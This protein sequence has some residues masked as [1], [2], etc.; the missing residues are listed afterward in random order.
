MPDLPTGTVTFLFTDVEGSTR[1][2]LQMGDH[3]ADL[4]VEYRRLLRAAFQDR[5]GQEIDT[6]GD[7]FF[8]AFPRAKDAVL[9]AV[10]AQR[11]IAAQY[12]PQD[13]A[14]RVRM[15][16]HTGE[17]LSA[18]TGYVGIDVNRAARICSAGHGGQ[19]L[20][21]Q[22]TRN[23]VEHDLPEGVSLRDLSEHRLKDLARPEHVYQ[24]VMP[25]L[26]SE[27]LPLKSLNILPNN[28]PIQ[29]AS[30]IGRERE[31]AE[32]KRLL[33][34][35]RLLTLIGPGGCGKTRLALHVVA[36]LI[37]EFPDGVWLAELAAVSDPKRVP[38]TVASA[39]G[40][41]EEPGRALLTTLSESLRAK[42]LLLVL[43]NCEHLVP[44]CADMANALLLVNPKL[45]I[46]TTSRQTLGTGGETVYSVPSLCVPDLRA[47]PSLEDLTQSEAV[48]LFV[49]RATL[50]RP[51]F[52][53][54]NANALAVAQICRS[55]DGIPLAIEL[56]AARVKVLSMPQIADRLEKRFWLLTGG[57]RTVLPR[58]QTLQAMMDWSY[59][60]LVEKERM[61]L[62]RLAVFVSGFALET[63][64]G[65]CVG[66]G[67]TEHEVMDLLTH[68]VDR[69]LVM[70][71][72]RGAETR[73]RL[74]E[75]V[76][77]YSRD[78]LLESGE[79][80]TVRK[81]HRDWYLALAER[82][83]PMLLGPDE[84]CLDRLEIE[85]DNLRAAL[86]QSLRS[87]EV[88]AGLRLA[89]A[90]S[91]FWQVRG[92]W[93]E[94]R[95]WL[96]TGL[97]ASSGT[98]PAL[99][100]KAMNAAGIL[101]LN[102]GDYERARALSEASLV[103]QRELEDKRGI[104]S[105]LRI[106]GNVMYEQGNYRAA[107]ELHE[108]S[109]AYG[110]EVDDKHAVA[111]SLVNLAIVAD[112]EGDYGRAV[113]LCEESLTLFREV[114]DT[115]G[116]AFALNMLGIL[117]SDQGDY[118]TARSRYEESL[119]IQRELGDKRGIASSLSNLARVAREQSDY[120]AARAL[121]E[122]S[123]AL[124]RE[125][126][127][128][129]GIASS[130]ANLGL[131]AWRQGDYSRATTL[132]GESLIMRRAQGNKAGIAECLEGFAR[133]AQDP[134]RA[135]R[136]FAA[137]AAV[138]AVVGA[139]LPPSDRPDYDRQLN[140]IRNGLGQE[141]F[142]AAWEQGWAMTLEQAIQNALAVATIPFNDP[143]TT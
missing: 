70:V 32:V 143:S 125:L 14:L 4:L 61:L 118:V 76:R 87:G 134:E 74:L 51:D 19:I 44:E 39:L 31:M 78:R 138:R 27:F 140:A 5:G 100:A 114:R 95:Q 77:Q 6:P 117:A 43:D 54:T 141:G 133:V 71:D 57:S 55:L 11:A 115:R 12:W 34:A 102:Q 18:A 86:E 35:T 24:V 83:E 105:S 120:T 85:H 136:L 15:A 40:V 68:L 58:Q 99:R 81:R 129:Q 49:E 46:L 67:V 75:T 21:S 63:A 106:L 123:L 119:V 45:K 137:A 89:G 1:L 139:P 122:E 9:A 132:F 30:F 94:G 16:L 130:L 23:L 52:R 25:D 97:D 29:L 113:S 110:R 62:R 47:R 17:P 22:T 116:T 126:G 10:A 65:V 107:G 88:E 37:D 142:A 36:D 121:Y 109:L 28:L 108:Q 33:S 64:E 104:G 53:L 73:Y 124:R 131:V 7:A 60:L 112:H 93:T 91:R 128:K 2:L 48:R 96:E 79:T 41:R 56:A 26:P 101:A 90:L 50:S 135:A 8:A 82:T 98:A 3:Y 80:P 13:I 72:Q 103:I 84:G 38:Q 42:Q 111:A 127:D 69:S 59:D 92:Y 20:L 66:N